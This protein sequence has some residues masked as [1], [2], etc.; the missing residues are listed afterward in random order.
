MTIRPGTNLDRDTLDLLKGKR[1]YT[2]KKMQKLASKYEQELG[3]QDWLLDQGGGTE[4]WIKEFLDMG[5]YS[6]RTQY[7]KLAWTPRD[8]AN[9]P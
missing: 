1:I 5:S 3:I 9:I 8:G 4:I 6:P 7:L 2:S